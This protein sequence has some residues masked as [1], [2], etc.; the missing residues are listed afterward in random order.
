MLFTHRERSFFPIGPL[1]ARRIRSGSSFMLQY[2]LMKAVFATLLFFIC[3]TTQGRVDPKNYDF[4][5][6]TLKDFFPGTSLEDI[7]KKYG[8]AEKMKPK[9]E[10]QMLRF[11]VA[12]IRYKFP[13]IVQVQEGKVLDMFARLPSYFLHDIFHQSVITRWGKQS[14]YK[15]VDEEAYYRWDSEEY[16]LHY[17]ASCTITCF[18]IYFSAQDKKNKSFSPLHEQLQQSKN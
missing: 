11:W 4:S 6:D 15:R 9:S 13:I 18:P 1:S 5:T 16:V 8:K 12:Q 2:F 10:P 14:Y 7:E 3:F 17:S